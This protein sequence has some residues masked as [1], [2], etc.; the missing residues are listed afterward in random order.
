MQQHDR[1]AVGSDVMNTAVPGTRGGFAGADVVEEELE[2]QASRA[3][4]ASCSRCAPVL[5]RGHQRED[6]PIAIA[7][8]TQPP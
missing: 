1:R 7:S 3:S 2:R 6:T 8:G 4:E 5:P